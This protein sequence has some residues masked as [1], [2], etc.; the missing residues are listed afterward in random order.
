MRRSMSRAP[1][2]RVLSWST[3]PRTSCSRR[4][5]IAGRTPSA[6][7]V[8]ARNSQT[9][10]IDIDPSPLNKNV[11][12]DV[13]IVGDAGAALEAIIAGLKG[14]RWK[15]DLEALAPWWKE[16]AGWRARNCLAYVNDSKIIKPQYA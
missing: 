13:P 3:C 9:I 11:R 8:T 1:A 6:T 15:P 14:R 5:P 10:P 12:V 4:A 16:I 2:G 7:R